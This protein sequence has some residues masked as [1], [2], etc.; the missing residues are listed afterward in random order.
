MSD[1]TVQLEKL[2]ALPT[3]RNAVLDFFIRLGKE[4]PLGV[5][6]AIIVLALLVTGVTS[7][8]LAPYEFNEIHLADRLSPPS[9]QYLLGTDEV[10]RDI[11][12]RIIRGARISMVVGLAA[13]AISVV[14]NVGIGI[15]SGYLGGKFD[16][17]VQ[18]FVDAWMCF[19]VLFIVL[20]LMALVGEGLTQV[21]IVL[22]I[23]YG[24]SGSRIVRGTVIGMKENMYVHAAVAIG[25]PTWRVLAKHILPNIMAPVIILFTIGVGG[26]IM[27]EA[28]ISFLGF[29][30][31]P[32]IAS[33]GNMLSGAGRTY[34]LQAP[35]LALWPGLALSVVVYGINM[36]GDAMR[37]LLDPR[38]RGGLG[39]YG[40]TVRGRKA[41]VKKAAKK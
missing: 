1:T 5:I 12:S 19:P 33:W 26:M 16:L 22:G 36:F 38:L 20:T 39:R 25:S 13:T 28:T 31:P 17:V 10:G 34:L 14:L 7:E 9:T 11:L 41:R 6:G 30:I 23:I 35:W 27:V 37:D 2:T 32:P 18:R 29:G 24:I 15:L 3:R 8:F 40:R 4:K 21:I